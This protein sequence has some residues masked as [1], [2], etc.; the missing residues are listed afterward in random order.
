MEARKKAGGTLD[1]QR[2]DQI[3]QDEY[4]QN[5][6]AFTASHG[7]PKRKR[8]TTPIGQ[9]TEDEFMES[10]ESDPAFAGIDI[11]REAGKMQAWCKYRGVQPTRR[12]LINWLMKAERTIGSSYDGRSSAAPAQGDVYHEPDSWQQKAARL[13]PEADFTGREWKELPITIRTEIIRKTS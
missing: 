2:V 6:K 12:R 4:D 13:Y 9:M 1:W 7:A 10:L 5:V 11:K 3:I 8:S